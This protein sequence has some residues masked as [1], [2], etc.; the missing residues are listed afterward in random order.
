MAKRTPHG[1]R[2][3]PTD[4]LLFA[5]FSLMR[6]A[7]RLNGIYRPSICLFVHGSVSVPPSI[8]LYLN[9]TRVDSR[10]AANRAVDG[11]TVNARVLDDSTDITVAIPNRCRVWTATRSE[12]GALSTCCGRT[13][14]LRKS[15]TSSKA[16]SIADR[17]GHRAKLVSMVAMAVAMPTTQDAMLMM[18]T[19]KLLV[20]Y[21]AHV[22]AGATRRWPCHCHIHSTRSSNSSRTR[23]LRTHRACQQLSRLLR[24]SSVD[25]VLHCSLR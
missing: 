8:P 9:L 23:L 15:S 25:C 19:P 17:I 6:F 20:T 7:D 21:R 24:V 1:R 14:R 4:R 12:R 10:D 3:Q 2:D 16:D 22:P 13:V 18:P 5:L 11:P